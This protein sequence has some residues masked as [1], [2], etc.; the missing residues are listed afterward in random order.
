[1]RGKRSRLTTCDETSPAKRLVSVVR[2]MV[3][4]AYTYSKRRGSHEEIGDYRPAIV[5]DR[6]C[7]HITLVAYFG[8]EIGVDGRRNLCID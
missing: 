3:V 7:Y 2:H 8:N 4:A 1:M 5:W 6:T